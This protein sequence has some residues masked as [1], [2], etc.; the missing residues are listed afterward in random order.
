MEA[1]GY[2]CIWMPNHPRANPWGLVYEHILKAEEILGRSLKDGEVVHHIDENRANNAY[3]N[4]LV[5]H[6]KANHTRF[7]KLNCPDEALEQ[8]ED[9]SY[10]CNNTKVICPICGSF[11]DHKANL[12]L[13]CYNLLQRKVNR[14]SREELKQLIRTKSFLAIGK[15]F[16]VSDNA[17][18]K[19]CDCEHLPRKKSDI[20]KYSDEEWNQL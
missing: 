17:I 1:N 11:K 8:L 18:R 12:C 15:Q 4:L 6:D 20:K 2:I 16:G 13:N 3:N 7:H 5:F 19:W 9:G 14:P 10:I